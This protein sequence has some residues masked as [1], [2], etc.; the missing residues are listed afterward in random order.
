MTIVQIVAIFTDSL[1]SWDTSRGAKLALF[2]NYR[3]RR[4]FIFY[5]FC[6]TITFMVFVRGV[7]PIMS[8]IGGRG[9]R[10]VTWFGQT[11]RRHDDDP[12]DRDY[13]LQRAPPPRL[14]LMANVR[15]TRPVPGYTGRD[16][17][18][19]SGDVCPD[20][21]ATRRRRSLGN[22]NSAVYCPLPILRI[23]KNVV[24]LLTT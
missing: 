12:G 8:T 6:P 10:E 7:R 21:A 17:Q 3:Q 11:T 24:F 9:L 19:I 4:Y 23:I 13:R 14:M 22:D 5:S 2:P 16:Y 18:V 20:L 1:T 15:L